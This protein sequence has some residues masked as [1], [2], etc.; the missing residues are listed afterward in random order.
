MTTRQLT[1]QYTV[2]KTA[3]FGAGISRLDMWK[4]LRGIWKKKKVNPIRYQRKL[5][6]E[7]DH[8]PV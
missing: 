6:D 7:A 8:M 1:K 5:R 2:N 3:F 4:A